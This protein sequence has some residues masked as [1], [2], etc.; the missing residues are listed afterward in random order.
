MDADQHFEI[1]A[2]LDALEAEIVRRDLAVPGEAAQVD[3]DAL[4][5]V[6]SLARMTVVRNQGDQDV[7]VSDQ[8]APHRWKV[9]ETLRPHLEES[10]VGLRSL[11]SLGVFFGLSWDTHL[12]PTPRGTKSSMF[13]FV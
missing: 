9:L 11:V 3:V 7:T 5:Y 12:G 10:G 4:R 8:L 6:V 2:P 13:L 1:R